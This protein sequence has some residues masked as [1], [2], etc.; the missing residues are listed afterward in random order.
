[1]TFFGVLEL[2][3]TFSSIQKYQ[4]KTV[5]VGSM[6]KLKLK[7]RKITLDDIN[8]VCIKL[9]AN[10][11]SELKKYHFEDAEKIKRKN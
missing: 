3:K 9:L 7:R 5:I 2:K 11:R 6:S 8:N 10:K 1:M 4:K